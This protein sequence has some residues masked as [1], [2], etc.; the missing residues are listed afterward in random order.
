MIYRIRVILDLA[1]DDVFRDIEI[2]ETATL[3]DLH[4][5]IANS[6]GFLG[7]EMASFY[8]S[9]DQWEQ[10][11]ELPLEDIGGDVPQQR[12]TPLQEVFSASETKLLYVYDFFEMWTFF[13]ERMEETE[14]T[15]GISYPN[16]VYSHGE[17]PEKAPEKNFE[18]NAHP[19]TDAF[20]DLQDYEERMDFDEDV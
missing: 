10:G 9:N 20:E 19:E 12:D 2:N 6:F 5:V 11:E 14:P 18:S 15:S 4:N 16:L 3:E 17:V 13:V 7:N 8:R 1:E